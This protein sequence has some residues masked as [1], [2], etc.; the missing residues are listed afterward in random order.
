MTYCSI[1]S[2]SLMSIIK[3]LLSFCSLIGCRPVENIHIKFGRIEGMSSRRGS[4][5]FLRDIL[6][7]A[8][9]RIADSM[10]TRK[11]EFWFVTVHA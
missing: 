10:H 5:V 11:S 8:R 9:D 1:S 6:D 3:F 4:V 7:E 2:A